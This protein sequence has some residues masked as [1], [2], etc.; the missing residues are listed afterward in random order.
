MGNL[1]QSA[2]FA[3]LALLAVSTFGQSSSQWRTAGDIREGMRGSVVGTVAD[4]D[5]AR[6]RVQLAP[7][8]SDS[9]RVLVIADATTRYNGFGGVINGQPEIL[10]GS[11]GFANVRAG[12]RLEVRGTGRG[13]GT[14]VATYI[15]LLGR[16]VPA[17]QTGAGTTRPPSTISTPSAATPSRAPRVG[18]IEGTVQQVN[19]AEG[20]IVIVTD[21]REVMTI[22]TPGG[23]PVHYRDE[24][25]R[26]ANLEVGDQIRID[27]D[28]A[29]SSSGEIR[30]RS[31]EVTRNVQEEGGTTVRATSLTGRVSR[32]DRTAD[33]VTIDT[34]RQPIRIDVSTASDDSGRRVRALDFRVGDQVSVTGR[35]SGTANDLLIADV[36]RWASDTRTPSR[37]EPGTPAGTEV[38]VGPGGE[39]PFVTIHGTV[40]ETLGNS[41]QIAVQD[42]TGRSVRINVLDDFLVRNRTGGTTTAD[43]LRNGDNVIVK[44]YRDADGNYIAQTIR[45][46]S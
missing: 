45:V 37:P 10:T 28:S 38:N 25:Y 22:R 41:P 6:S 11:P 12:D 33:L 19:A 29:R 24:T 46:R 36:V 8:D 16:G 40:R 26:V 7:D 34:G 1:R 44:A 35:S 14:V 30:A 15:T 21:H 42:S 43:Q 4:V 13:T 32:V 18:A 3:I 27:A 2:V 23:T 20:R 9:G 31:I 17:D 39:L 5:E